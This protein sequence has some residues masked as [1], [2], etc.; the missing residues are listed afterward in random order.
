M[1]AQEICH[2]A[3]EHETDETGFDREQV[4][5]LWWHWLR[6]GQAACTTRPQSLSAPMHQVPRIGQDQKSRELKAALRQ[7]AAC[8]DSGLKTK[9]A[10]KQRCRRKILRSGC[11]PRE[12]SR[13]RCRSAGRYAIPHGTAV[14]IRRTASPGTASTN[15]AG[16]AEWFETSSAEPLTDKLPTRQSTAWPANL[17]VPAFTVG[18]GVF[19]RASAIR[20]EWA[21]IPEE[22]VMHRMKKPWCRKQR[23][24]QVRRPTSFLPSCTP[25]FRACLSGDEP[26]AI[27]RFRICR[28]Q[29][30]LLSDH[31]TAGP[32]APASRRMWLW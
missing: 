12:L 1:R 29:V 7:A 22:P 6:F 10:C 24:R 26:L 15:R 3:S 9:A 17:I 8:K 20:S 5:H 30:P 25:R 18:C 13:R 31:V 2:F 11:R 32:C 4:R 21:E 28:S 27:C 23:G 19:L 14:A 16:T